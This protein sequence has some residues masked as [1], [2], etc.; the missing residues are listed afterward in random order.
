MGYSPSRRLNP[1]SAMKTAL[2]LV[3]LLLLTAVPSLRAAFQPITV[4]VTEEPVMPAAL[5][6]SGVLNGRVSVAIN[7]GADGQ[8]LDWL[9]L[10]ASHREL[11]KPCV[12]ALKQWRFTPA[13][14][15]GQP[16]LAQMHLSIDI[17]QT[18]V[19]VSRSADEMMSDLFERLSGRPYDYQ[20]CPA[21]EIDHQPAVL[22]TVAPRY[23]QEA[24]KE[25]VRGRVK[26]YFYI[27]EQGDVRM[28]AVPAD[29]HPYLSSVAIEALKGWKFEP[30]TRHGRPVLVAAAQE[31]S[32]GGQ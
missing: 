18:G 2:R 12:E 29:T 10:G 9:V 5:R 7:I 15:D 3:L 13:R 24:E 27:D 32:F 1:I 17:N 8:P 25:G 22:A 14:F 28:P 19:V 23:A 16:V 4:Q 26:V 6:M 11:I 30:P 21:S 20:A 31:F